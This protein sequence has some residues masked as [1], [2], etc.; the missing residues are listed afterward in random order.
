MKAL[1]S[2]GRYAS[3]EK[4]SAQESTSV[5]NTNKSWRLAERWIM[6]SG[7]VRVGAC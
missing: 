4:M 7:L 6:G 3:G 1:A 2:M 5:I